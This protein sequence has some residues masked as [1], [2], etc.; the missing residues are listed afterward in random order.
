[1]PSAWTACAFGNGL[2]VTLVEQVYA[3]AAKAGLLMRCTLVSQNG[4]REVRDVE[5]RTTDDTVF[6]N[7]VMAVETTITV[8]NTYF[9]RAQRGDLCMVN[10]KTYQIRDIRAIHDGSEIKFKVAKV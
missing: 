4:L 6:D 1:M 9:H 3:A 5:F 2:G 8:P 7:L 10:G